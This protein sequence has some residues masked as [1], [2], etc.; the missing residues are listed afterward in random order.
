MCTTRHILTPT[1]K[2]SPPLSLSLSLS[3]SLLPP[4]PGF[5]RMDEQA[6]MFILRKV[7]THFIAI[8]TEQ[9]KTLPDDNGMYMYVGEISRATKLCNRN[10]YI[11]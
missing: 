10:E 1:W 7:V 4:S 11:M 3:L 8:V 2:Y 9:A 6:A 5:G